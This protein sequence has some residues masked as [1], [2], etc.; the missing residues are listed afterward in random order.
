LYRS[1]VTQANV[2][3]CGENEFGQLGA[4]ENVHSH[5]ALAEVELDGKKGKQVAAGTYCS[6][7]V[8]E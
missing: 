5:A 7:V 4:P 8:S 2:F 3:T 6:F 1:D